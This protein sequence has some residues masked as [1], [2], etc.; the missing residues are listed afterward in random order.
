[1]ASAWL[2]SPPT[3]CQSATGQLGG[4]E[5]GGAFGPVLD[6]RGEVASLG[7]AQRWDQPVVDGEQVE[8][9]DAG[10]EPRVGPV[11]PADGAGTTTRGGP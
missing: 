10:Q 1:M 3:A 9:G 8:L 4:D 11:S 7:V 6:D 2:A 5:S